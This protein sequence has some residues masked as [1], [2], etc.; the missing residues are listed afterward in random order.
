MAVSF[1]LLDAIIIF[2]AAFIPSIVYLVWIRNT[3]RY[4]P[5]PYAR[6]LRIFAYGAV[7]SIL[8]A[9]VAELFATSLFNANIERFYRFFGQNPNLTSLFLAIIIAPFIE[10]LTKSIG[11]FSLRRHM[12]DIEDGIIYGAAAGLGFAATENLLYES[13]AFLSQGTGAFLETAAVRSISSALLHASAS[14]VVGLGIARSF[15]QGKSWLPY[16]LLGVGMHGTFN[17]FASF[18]DLYATDLG[19]AASFI[20]FLA[21]VAMAIIAISLIRSKIRVLDIESARTAR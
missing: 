7:I 17:F 3:E 15:R 20:G 8:I 4:A 21:A 19:A 12:S 5:E 10:E 6:L 13:S 16:Y 18:G 11:V 2:L 9:I 14:A 1:S